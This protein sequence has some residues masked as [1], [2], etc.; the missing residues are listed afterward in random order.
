[1]A[2]RSIVTDDYSQCFL[3]KGPKQCIHHIYFGSGRRNISDREGF[4]VPLC[5]ACHKDSM[6]GVHGKYGEKNALYLK[7]VC[8]EKYEE[9]HTR[10][11]FMKL[12]GRNYL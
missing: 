9:T 6:F 11:E 3:C 1:M 2:K 8:Q 5:N 12:I 7:Q 4:V 10:E